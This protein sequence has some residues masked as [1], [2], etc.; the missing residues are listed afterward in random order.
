MLKFRTMRGQPDYAGS[1]E[2]GWEAFAQGLAPGGVEGADRRTRFGRLLRRTSLD[3][4]PQLFNVLRGEMS[5]VGPR[6]SGPSTCERLSSGYA[7]TT[8]ATG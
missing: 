2:A 3:E 1:F 5:I 8:S 4:L 6:P 7:A